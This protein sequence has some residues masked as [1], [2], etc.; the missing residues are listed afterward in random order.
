MVNPVDLK[1]LDG[2]APVSTPTGTSFG[3]PW[4]QG[5]IDKT[6]PISLNA[7]GQSQKQRTE[8]QHPSWPDGSLK[9]TGHTVPANTGLSD[10]LTLQTGTP[11]EPSTP[12]SVADNG[13]TITVK[14]GD[15][16]VV[17][18]KSTNVLINSISSA[19]K[20]QVSNGTLVVHVQDAPDEPELTGP[21][22]T[23]K[24]ST[25]KIESVVVEQSG[26]VRAV[27]KVTGKYTGEHSPFLPWT[28][29]FYIAAGATALRMV[30]FF[31]Y[32]ADQNK[33]FIKGLG[34][35]FTTPLTDEFY[36]RH[37]R[38]V[39]ADGGIW[40]EPVLVM[41]GLRRDATAAVLLPQF[42]GTATSDISTWPTSITP[43][44]SEL[45]VWSDYTLDQLSSEYFTIAKRTNAGRAASFIPHAGFGTRASGV[46]CVGG[47]TG[48][49][50]VFGLPKLVLRCAPSSN[51]A[52]IRTYNAALIALKDF[53][54][55]HMI[56]VTLYI[57]QPSK[58]LAKEEAERQGIDVGTSHEVKGSAGGEL[59][60]LLKDF[61]ERTTDALLQIDVNYLTVG[62]TMNPLLGSDHF[63]SLPR[64][65]ILQGTPA[66]VP[67]T[68]TLAAHDFDVDTRTGFMPPQ[69]PPSRLPLTWESW[70]ESLAEAQRLRLQLGDTP[71]LSEHERMK[72][73]SWRSHV[74]SL[75]IIAI[76][77]LKT[78]EL[79]LRRAH[80]VLGWILHF[81]IHSLPP[82]APVVIPPP[83]TLPLLQVS[84]E[85]QLPPVLTY[86]D[87][88]LY[89][90]E[91]KREQSVYQPTP[92]LDNL[93]CQTL[94]TGTTDEEEFYL[95]SARIELAGVAALELMQVIMDEAFVGDDIAIRRITE[96]L[97]SLS[98]TIQELRLLL[99]AVREGCNPDVFYHHI[100]PWFR[101]V[102]SDPLKR[103]WIFEGIEA[104]TSLQ[105]PTELSGPSAGQ[106]SLVH[107][108]DIFLGVDQYSHSNSLTGS[109]SATAKK[110]FL[111]RMQLYMPRH[112]RTFLN[113]LSANPR[114][115]REIVATRNDVGLRDAY[116]TA[117]LAL[118][119]FRDAHMIIVAQFIIGPSRRP[120]PSISVATIRSDI[121][122]D[123]GPSE[124]PLKGTGG[125]E[126]VNFLKG[127]RDRTAGAVLPSI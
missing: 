29:R 8:A 60:H 117:V 77:D 35:R 100:R 120:A 32:D 27:I 81:Y 82:D 76:D 51:Q 64:P 126:L 102:D 124:A 11:A 12:V 125:T 66:G 127:V 69:S 92:A 28:V 63:L 104:D 112:H 113:H 72:S 67:D 15:F 1:W 10:T 42:E 109:S 84:A 38:F 21:R 4:N 7:S 37:I 54:D 115:L 61:R 45:A 111:D 36:N 31:I 19:G 44:V 87:D 105:Q 89:N 20:A 108:L 57:I 70:E 116:N 73:E 118:K 101:G 88:V 80:H 41:S 95:S 25:G 53:R 24:E 99:L 68:T 98:T 46:G 103:P 14:T 110:A 50:V 17:F 6:T 55:S 96:Y 13:K 106:S 123:Y 18:N 119:E 30:H 2:S 58:R 26:P 75:D 107:A 22:P 78:S 56:I 34:L 5:E 3:I 23:V 47:A 49:S 114:P 91:L 71:N 79:Y 74:R 48:G 43:F 121:K 52:E 9:W 94:F 65:D 62:R 93:R 97:L 90:W 40:G 85:L 33:D 59:A 122:K 39:S 16:S 86:S 83:I